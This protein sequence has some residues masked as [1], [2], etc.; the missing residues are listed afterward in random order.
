M[1][2]LHC[3]DVMLWRRLVD[4][5]QDKR[6]PLKCSA[7][8]GGGFSPVSPLL[9]TPLPQITRARGPQLRGWSHSRWC[10]A[11]LLLVQHQSQVSECIDRWRLVSRAGARR[12]VRIKGHCNGC[13]VILSIRSDRAVHGCE[14]S[15]RTPTDDIIKRSQTGTTDGRHKAPASCRRIVPFR[16][17]PSHSRALIDTTGLPMPS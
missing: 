12:I 2:S 10:F 4:S 15:C 1:I 17:H 9:R 6:R 3:N 8:R 7:F 13:A 5:T 11:A 14:W 16:S